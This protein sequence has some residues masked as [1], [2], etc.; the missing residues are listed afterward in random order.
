MTLTD[1]DQ[2][3]SLLATWVDAFRMGLN[4]HFRDE[5]LDLAEVQYEQVMNRK[6]RR[7]CSS[8]RP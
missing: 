4:P 5:T 8:Q 2:I 1:R 7:I 6:A 3:E